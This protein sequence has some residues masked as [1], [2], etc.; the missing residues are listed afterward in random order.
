MRLSEMKNIGKALEQLLI[1]VGIE[2]PEDLIR[3][4][5]IEA[6]KR[7]KLEGV[8]CYNKLFALEGAILDTRWHNLSKDE[9]QLLKNKYDE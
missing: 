7:L 2:T 3:I 1:Q 9:L 8:A 6:T 4:G 5:S